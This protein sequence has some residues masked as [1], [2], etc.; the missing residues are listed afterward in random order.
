MIEKNQK[1]NDATI[2]KT[3]SYTIT[4]VFLLHRKIR[5]IYSFM[6]YKAFK[7]LIR[8]YPILPRRSIYYLILF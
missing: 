6:L 7:Y 2:T 3:I 5:F 4:V 8:Q 1:L